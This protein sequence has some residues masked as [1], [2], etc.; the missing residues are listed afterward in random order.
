L[1]LLEGLGISGIISTVFATICRLLRLD[2]DWVI[3]IGIFIGS[4][5][6]LALPR[7]FHVLCRWLRPRTLTHKI[8]FDY[9]PSNMMD[10]GWT[11]AYPS[12]ATEKPKATLVSGAPIAGSIAMDAPEGHA[13]NY[14]LPR[15]A[16]L[17]DS[18]EYAAKYKPAT[19]IFIMVELSSKDGTK[20]EC[21]WI[22][23]VP[24]SGS[25]QQTSN[26]KDEWT[27][28]IPGEPMKN[29][30][31]KFAISLPDAVEKTWG[32]FGYIFKAVTAFRLRGNPEISP[33][34]FYESAKRPQALNLQ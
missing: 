6:L 25:P 34:D 8:T 24:G 22:K 30:W 10:N 32:K 20:T 18:L 28:P 33:I 23:P 4:C 2:V 26:N 21:K 7:L 13:Y 15:N 11:R 29:E 19:M 31:R 5:V 9:L 12:D 1:W 16:R 27:L 14:E 3:I 17:S